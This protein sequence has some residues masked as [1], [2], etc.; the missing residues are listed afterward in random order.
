MRV[1]QLA[2]L[3]YLPGTALIVLSWV[4]IV[5]PEVGWL[6]FAVAGIG[7]LMSYLPATEDRFYYPLTQEGFPVE[8][9]GNPVPAD[10]ALEAGAPLLAFSQ[11][12][13]WRATVIRAEEDG[14]VLVNYPGWDSRWVE[15]LPRKL[16]Q[17][18]PD[19]NRAP[20]QLPPP[21][22]LQRL[23]APTN[24]EAV[25]PS[26]PEGVRRGTEGGKGGAAD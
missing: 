6:G 20:L 17:I 19:P 26:G 4:R 15:R 21:E 24:A 18:D 8:P 12:R 14:T 9:P 11:G 1:R 10:L 7:A 13:W 5:P 23:A 16:L 22:V 25:K 3:L 2:W